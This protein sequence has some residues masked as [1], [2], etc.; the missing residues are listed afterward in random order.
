[1]CA[2]VR[3][4]IAASKSCVVFFACCAHFSTHYCALDEDH[5]LVQNKRTSW[6]EPHISQHLVGAKQFRCTSPS[7]HKACCSGRSCENRL[8]SAT[9]CSANFRQAGRQSLRECIS[10]PLSFL[11]GR[12]SLG[13]GEMYASTCCFLEEQVRVFSQSGLSC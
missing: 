10:W 12:F 2:R 9:T 5:V 3:A 4:Y 1:M 6:V 13:D 7:M 8:K 11:L